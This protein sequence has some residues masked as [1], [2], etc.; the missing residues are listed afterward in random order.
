MIIKSGLKDLKE[1]IKEMSENQNENERP[2]EIVNLVENIF[3][4]NDQ[5]QNQQWQGL[6][7]LTLILTNA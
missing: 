6:K 3:E 2:D 4:F 1:Q 5:N 7:V